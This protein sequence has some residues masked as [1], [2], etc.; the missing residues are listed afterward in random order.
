MAFLLPNAQ[1]RRLSGKQPAPAHYVVPRAVLAALQ[2]EAWSEIAALSEDARRKH[3]HWVHVRTH[4]LQQK[5]PSSFTR[6]AFWRHME[7]VYKDVYPNAA[8]RTGSILLFGVVAKERHRASGREQE[9]EEHH[10]CPCY[11]AAAHYWRPVAKRSLEL[12]VKLHAACHDGYTIM[13]AYVK[14]P[15]RKKPLAELDQQLW[16]SE[17]HPKGEVLQKLLEVG[18]QATRWL[19]KRK[20]SESSL[21]AEGRFRVADLFTLSQREGLRTVSALRLCAHDRATQGDARLAE[22]CTTHREQELQ[23]FLDNAW[24]VHEAPQQA[25]GTSLGRMGKLRL[26]AE[27][28]CECN[29]QWEGGVRFILGQQQE[30][31]AVF[32]ADVLRALD[33]GAARGVNMAIVG[34]PGCGKSTVFESL[35]KIYKVSAKPEV[36]STFSLAGILDAEVLLW[37][38]FEWDPKGVAFNDLLAVLA[39]EQVGIRQ[40]GTKQQEH[41]NHA[42]M[43]YTSW[44]ALTMTCRDQR[45]M[46][47]LNGAM[48]ERFKTRWWMRPLPMQGRIA[49]YPQCGRCFAKFLLENASVQP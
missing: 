5:Q 39:A 31:V 11:T 47:N 10:H 45:R 49:P 15:T 18:A 48:G 22:F 41:C 21:A 42:P 2:D 27:W 17:D 19:H 1:K 20:L 16:F 29:G 9:R 24:H 4:E 36:G 6:E 38:E 43:F 30:D 40:P 46:G 12:G 25:L 3:M 26:A 28:A 7:R 14:N 37:Q 33:V 8:N 35:R 13:Y 32:C 34:V 44:Q 23:M